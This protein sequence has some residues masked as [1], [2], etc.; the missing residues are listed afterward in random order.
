VTSGKYIYFYLT[1][2]LTKSVVSAKL[3]FMSIKL[4]LTMGAVKTEAT[5]KDA[6]YGELMTFIFK[7]Q[8][9]ASGPNVTLTPPAIKTGDAPKVDTSIESI[10]EWFKRH[11]ASEV[12]NRIGWKTNPEKIVLL[13][14]FHESNG[15]TEA[16]RSSEI[17]ERFNQAKEAF[18]ANFPRDI[19]ATID[20]G[21]VGAV[22][23]RTYK[24]GRAGWNKIANAIKEL[25]TQS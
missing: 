13:A 4:T 20:S 11:T 6:A 25:E 7:Y 16:W 19:R 5:I 23:P 21:D 12:L 10:K 22:T 8:D 3:G 1:I 18:P 24:V 9:G 17:N 14:A 15:G 2:Y